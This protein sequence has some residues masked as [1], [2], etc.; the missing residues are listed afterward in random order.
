M[1]ES[2]PGDEKLGDEEVRS[3]GLLEIGTS[4]GSD[5]GRVPW[6]LCEKSFAPQYAERA[7]SGDD[8]ATTE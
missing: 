6:S 5:L 3:P 2:E 8:A 7:D 4:M 1:I